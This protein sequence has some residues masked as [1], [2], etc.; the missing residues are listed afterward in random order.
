MLE[1]RAARERALQDLFA[2]ETS[3]QQTLNE[4][5]ATLDIQDSELS[6]LTEA[7][8]IKK[9]DVLNRIDNKKLRIANLQGTLRELQREETRTASYRIRAAECRALRKQISRGYEERKI[10]QD[11]VDELDKKAE[12]LKVRCKTIDT[13]EKTVLKNI[14]KEMQRLAEDGCLMD[15]PKQVSKNKNGLFQLGENIKAEQCLR[16]SGYSFKKN[17]YFISM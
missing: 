12:L 10:L 16:Q 7:V 14:S 1:E 3:L 6:K 2:Q 13:E 15:F 4:V 9:E 11:N 8:R 17:E 5:N